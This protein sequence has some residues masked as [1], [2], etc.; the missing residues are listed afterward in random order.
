MPKF[1]GT[2]NFLTRESRSITSSEKIANMTGALGACDGATLTI[3]SNT[4]AGWPDISGLGGF[5]IEDGT[6][7]F[8]NSNASDAV[9]GGTTVFKSK[10]SQLTAT[11]ALA[12]GANAKVCF[13]IPATGLTDGVVPIAAPTITFDSATGLE[14]D[15]AEFRKTLQKKV[16]L[17]L[18]TA[19]TALT[20][21]DAVLDAA[22]MNASE[23]GCRFAKEGNSLFLEM[24]KTGGFVL[25]VR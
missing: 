7:A 4:A 6:V 23:T 18:A 9:V 2:G 25:F 8:K 24:S 22:N 1:R 3:G 21:P 17:T 10:S 11:A 5:V 14:V 20:L 19:S 15:A 13:E 12:F 16:R